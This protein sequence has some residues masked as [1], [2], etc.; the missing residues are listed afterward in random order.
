MFLVPGKLGASKFN[1]YLILI[2]FLFP[3]KRKLHVIKTKLD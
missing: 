1:P 3:T 2:A